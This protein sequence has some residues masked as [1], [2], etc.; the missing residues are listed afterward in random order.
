MREYAMFLA[1]AITDATGEPIPNKFPELFIAHARRLGGDGYEDLGSLVL[2]ECL[3]SHKNG[4]PL[5]LVAIRRHPGPHSSP[6]HQKYA[7]ETHLLASSLPGRQRRCCTQARFQFI[8]GS[9]SS[10]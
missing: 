2:I 5:D 1:K 6:D 10:R 8:S 4:T 7:A 3:E 9:S